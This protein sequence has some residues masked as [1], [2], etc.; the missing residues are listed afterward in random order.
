MTTTPTDPLDPHN[1]VAKGE[2]LATVPE[3]AKLLGLSR[4][5]LDSVLH[6][7]LAGRVHFVRTPPGGGKWLYAVEDAKAAIAPLLP[8]L[9]EARKRRAE[10]QA[11]DRADAANRK[12]ERQAGHAAHVA[13]KQARER[14]GKPPPTQGR[15]KPVAPSSAPSSS[16]RHPSARGQSDRGARTPPV[17][18]VFVR[19]KFS[20][21]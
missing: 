16:R 6:G 20:E 2:V 7:E 13:R 15:G 3:I 4:S 14:K 21:E 11:R 9:D 1:L 17:P 8:A 5:E 18:E 12:A 19:R 10:R